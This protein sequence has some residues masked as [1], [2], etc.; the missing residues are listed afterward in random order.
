MDKVERAQIQTKLLLRDYFNIFSNIEDSKNLVETFRS[1]F[2]SPKNYWKHILKH[3][4]PKSIKHELGLNTWKDV[5]KHSQKIFPY[6]KN[7]A[8]SF[9]STLAYPEK[10]A[11]V[12][13]PK[14][15]FERI[16]FFSTKRKMAVILGPTGEVASVY[17][18]DR[19][20]DWGEWKNYLLSQ[21]ETVLEVPI[22]EET[23]EM[24]GR[25]QELY[26]RLVQR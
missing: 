15:E 4:I 14:S 20:K 16:V 23:K 3:A 7:Y 17:E 5:K 24:A 2:T 21:N 11:L 8:L 9:L 1:L 12:T 22:D 13:S 6:Q 18:L 19:F 10:I 26:R 25:I